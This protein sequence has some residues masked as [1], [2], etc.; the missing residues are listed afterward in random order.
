MQRVDDRQA[1]GVM[2]GDRDEGFRREDGKM[3]NE[4]GMKK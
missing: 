3:G 2:E 1:D 4:E